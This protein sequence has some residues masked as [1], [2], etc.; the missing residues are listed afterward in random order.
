MRE[1]HQNLST[2]LVRVRFPRDRM[3]DVSTPIEGPPSE[4]FGYFC[5]RS[6]SCARVHDATRWT[7]TTIMTPTAHDAD[8]QPPDQNKRRLCCLPLSF[9]LWANTMAPKTFHFTCLF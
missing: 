6:R 4:T 2:G 1:E 5:P 3:C 8:N 7:N 9:K